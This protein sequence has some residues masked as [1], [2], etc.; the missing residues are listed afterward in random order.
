[1]PKRASEKHFESRRI[2]NLSGQVGIQTHADHQLPEVDHE[3]TV[4]RYNAA[5]QY[6]SA[7]LFSGKPLPSLR[8]HVALAWHFSEKN[9][10]RTPKR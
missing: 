10:K 7:V 4:L 1:M 5:L 3:S 9:Q 6:R 8:L 2:T